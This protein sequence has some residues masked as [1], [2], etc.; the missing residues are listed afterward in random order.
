MAK[1]VKAK[2]GD[3]LCNIAFLH[4]F[5]DCIAL[6][7]EPKNKYIL[8]RKGDEKAQ[9]QTGDKVTI[10]KMT[11]KEVDGAT[12]QRH[13]FVKRGT[14]AILRFVHGS[15]DTSFKNDRTLPCLNVSNFVTNLA[16]PPDGATATPFPNSSVR[17]FNEHADKDEDAFKVE[18]LD[19]NA[20][21]ELEVELEVLKPVYDAK[22]KVTRHEPFP[23]AIRATR[24]LKPNPKASK[25]GATQRFRTCYLRLVVDD[26]DKGKAPAGAFKDQTLL[27]SDMFDPA[28]ATTKQVEIL[29]QKVK[30]SYVIKTCPKD[31]KC[32]STVIL[33]IG[34]DRKRIKLAIHVL[35]RTAGGALVVPLDQAE[36]RIWT[37]FRRVY[38][39]ASIGP[40]LMQPVRGV[41]PPENLVSISNDD[42]K[43]A[44]GD[45]QLSFRINADGV[46]SQTIS[47]T[48]TR[49]ARPITTA[50]ALAA[51]IKAPFRAAVTQNPPIF[52]S[53]R[54]SA[55]IVVTEASRKRVTI[56]L[57]VT[58]DSDQSLLVGRVRVDAG[59]GTLIVQSWDG[60]NWLVGSI[61]QRAVLKN[62]DTGDDRVDIFVVDTLSAG[63]GGEAMMSGHRVDAARRAI[64]KVKWSAF[65]IASMMDN[66]NADPFAFPHEVGHV[67]GEVVHTDD[68]EDFQLMN[69]NYLGSPNAIGLRKRI[70]DATAI[71][72]NPV[73]NFNLVSRLRRE[74]APVMEGW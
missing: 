70:R 67:V 10:P 6:R 61:Q 74:G 39:Q 40:K 43:R 26:A 25:Q 69:Q 4:G 65:I 18:V 12:E 28:D 23:A 15:K 29:D 31:P 53:T 71:Y 63:S 5:G 68:V 58:D 54:R 72:T 7:E 42:G 21:G 73:G 49:G 47:L 34:K 64:S 51:Q 55:D 45:G 62:H 32:R 20:S 27:A 30:G 13:K 56:D 37:W 59:T 9:L 19:I 35:R 33:P 48:P 8:D 24:Q 57:E 66:T 17:D 22:G 52:G 38:A 11:M 60:T 16:G 14:L 44:A 46:A 50:N 2:E 36:G 1:T 3:S 41:D